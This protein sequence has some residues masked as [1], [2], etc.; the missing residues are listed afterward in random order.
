VGVR[1]SRKVHVADRP[2]GQFGTVDDVVAVVVEEREA[3]GNRPARLGALDEPLWVY[4]MY[5]TGALK[6]LANS[7]LSQREKS[8]LIGSLIAKVYP[9]RVASLARGAGA[10]P[11]D[12]LARAIAHEIGHLLMGNSRHSA[13]GLMRAVWSREEL[14]RNAP[15]TGSFQRR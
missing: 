14:R 6:R 10:D 13:R 11:A 12:L 5:R 1:R 7:A 15:P 3:L 2:T 9:D 8:R 4:R